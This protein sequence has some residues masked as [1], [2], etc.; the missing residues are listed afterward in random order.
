MYPRRKGAMA[1]IPIVDDQRCFQRLLSKELI[2]EGYE[3]RNVGDTESVR[4][5]LHLFYQTR[6]VT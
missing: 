4:E 5:H 2:L 6:E 1:K 3:A